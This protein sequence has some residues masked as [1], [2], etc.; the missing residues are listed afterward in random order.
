[1]DLEIFNARALEEGAQATTETLE[2]RIED[3]LKDLES[4]T[5]RTLKADEDRL[6]SLAHQSGVYR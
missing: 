1:M 5:V 4:A 3:A 6:N 2:R